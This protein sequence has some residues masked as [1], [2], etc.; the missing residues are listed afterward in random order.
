VRAFI[1]NWS[2]AES[3]ISFF[4]RTMSEFP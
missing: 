4:S 3:L 1:L 2:G